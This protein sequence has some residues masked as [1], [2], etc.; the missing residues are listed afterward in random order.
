MIGGAIG[1]RGGVVIHRV[2]AVTIGFGLIIH[3]RIFDRV[4]VPGPGTDDPWFQI[5]TGQRVIQT[6]QTTTET[7]RKWLL[8]RCRVAAVL[9]VGVTRLLKRQHRIFLAVGIQVTNHQHSIG[10]NAGWAGGQIL[11]QPLRSTR[12]LHIAISLT[13]RTF[14]RL[15]AAGTF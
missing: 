3:Q 5:R 13:V 7:V 14:V 2:K 6:A 12:T 9:Q 8:F 11:N 1:V 10:T 4:D 15:S